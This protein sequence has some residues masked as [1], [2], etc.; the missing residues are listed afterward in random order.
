M[1]YGNVPVYDLQ[2]SSYAYKM[3]IWQ[4]VQ[5]WNVKISAFRQ[6]Q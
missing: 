5:I 6:F 1:N 4:T 3:R 2:A